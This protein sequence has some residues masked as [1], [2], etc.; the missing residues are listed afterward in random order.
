MFSLSYVFRALGVLLR[1][2]S[3]LLCVPGG[4]DSV[5]DR[6]DQ[7]RRT[8]WR[9]KPIGVKHTFDFYIY[10]NPSDT[11]I[12]PAIGLT[13]S[14]EP[15]I[16]ELFRKIL[17][18]GMTVV[19]VGANIGWF[20]LLSATIVGDTGEV[21]SVEPEP[22]NFSFLLRSVELNRFSNVKLFQVCA[23]NSRGNQILY[24]SSGNLGAHST[25][26]QVS[27]KKIEV[28]SD[29]LD[30]ILGKIGVDKI[31]L[32]KI[33]VEGAEPY[34]LE[35]CKEHLPRTRNIIIEWNPGE[36]KRRRNLL[37]MILREFDVYQI[38]RSPF[39]IKKITK[40]SL[41]SFNTSA[42]NL[43]MRRKSLQQ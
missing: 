39:L 6:I 32:L 5:A 2:P 16:T 35:G 8:E 31:D 38:V 12:S 37:K 24:L 21:V 36:W 28:P 15:H 34:V 22:T 40:D 25:I 29:T 41:L 19:D 17:A 18:K 9:L 7:L 42:A 11:I 43:Y 14:H 30:A 26:N 33:D 27:D 20:T 23:S 4:F 13:G 10:L 3:A 1:Y